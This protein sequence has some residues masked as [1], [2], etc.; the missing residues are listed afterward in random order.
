MAC[1]EVKLQ[2][3]SI[4]RPRVRSVRL[5]D[6][7]A[8]LGISTTTFWRWQKRKD[9]PRGMRLSPG[10]TVYDLDAL[11]QWRDSHAA[12]RPEQECTR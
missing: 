2:G 6:A 11:I 10:C 12:E 7:A 8:A 1:K 3:L 9:M 5:K 4:D